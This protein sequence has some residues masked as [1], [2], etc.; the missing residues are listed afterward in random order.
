MRRVDLV[1]RQKPRGDGLEELARERRVRRST[2]ARVGAQEFSRC[3]S[4]FSG[5]SAAQA[6]RRRRASSSAGR[7]ADLA[8]VLLGRW[9]RRAEAE[10][11]AQRGST[12][13]RSSA[14]RRWSAARRCARGAAGRRPRSRCP[15]PDRAD[16]APAARRRPTRRTGSARPDPPA[17]RRRPRA[18]RGEPRP[19]TQEER[20]HGIVD[21]RVGVRERLG[22]RVALVEQDA[23][24]G[25]AQLGELACRRR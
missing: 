3:T 19:G 15:T 17:A 8:R 2:S 21:A 7:A 23:E 10:E 9:Q 24:Q 6:S 11:L 12:V 16:R 22:E 20:P 18:N 5:R 25:V 14:G 13:G 4:S 1:A